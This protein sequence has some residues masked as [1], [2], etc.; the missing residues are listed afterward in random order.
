M[1]H[2]LVLVK[3]L[4]DRGEPIKISLFKDGK[5]YDTI[6]NND[7]TN[8]IV[9]DNSDDHWTVMEEKTGEFRNADKTGSGNNDC[10]FDCLA[11]YTNGKSADELRNL[12]VAG[13]N[14]NQ[15]YLIHFMPAYQSASNNPDLF[16]GMWSG[17]GVKNELKRIQGKMQE[18]E[19]QGLNKEQIHEKI[20]EYLKKELRELKMDKR[21]D[22]IDALIKEVEL[23][24]N[25]NVFATGQLEKIGGIIYLIKKIDK[26]D[27]KKSLELINGAFTEINDPKE[28]IYQGLIDCGAKTN[29]EKK[30][31][32]AGNLFKQFTFWYKDGKT[33]IKFESHRSESE[34]IIDNTSKTSSH[35]FEAKIEPKLEDAKTVSLGNIGYNYNNSTTKESK[36]TF[37]SENTM[38]VITRINEDIWEN[39]T[40]QFGTSKHHDNFGSIFGLGPQKL[41][42]QE[43]KNAGWSSDEDN[44]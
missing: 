22:L 14:E 39:T 34:T 10:L 43:L 44:S 4:E 30:I 19:K 21:G 17:A 33:F 23:Y 37:E 11:K 8:C 24:K 38:R 40:S 16:G 7:S 5:Y 13:L 35:N 32:R 28:E 9:I 6:G 20:T 42:I 15:D 12:T 41:D 26:V 18:Y 25:Y 31:L 29:G 1:L 2:L 36:Y 3:E 27:S